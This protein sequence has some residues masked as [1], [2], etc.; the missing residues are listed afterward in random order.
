MGKSM[1]WGSY[2]FPTKVRIS[3]NLS[4]TKHKVKADCTIQMGMCISGSGKIIKPM[5]WANTLQLVVLCMMANG[6]RTKDVGKEG[7]SGVTGLCLKVL[8]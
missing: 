7:K 8:T 1:E 2:I 3:G 4:I 6:W 5:G